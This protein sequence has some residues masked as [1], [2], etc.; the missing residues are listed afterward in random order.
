[1]Y[2][3]ILIVICI[4]FGLI[5]TDYNKWLKNIEIRAKNNVNWGREYKQIQVGDVGY[6]CYF[7]FGIIESISGIFINIRVEDGTTDTLYFEEWCKISIPPSEIFEYIELCG[8][9]SEMRKLITERH[10]DIYI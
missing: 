5:A 10:I 3:I 2:I 6:G 8:C 7:G 9:S 4:F 1:M